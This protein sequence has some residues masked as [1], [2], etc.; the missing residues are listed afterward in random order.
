MY[1]SNTRDK[2]LKKIRQ[3]LLNKSPSPFPEPDF[4]GSV[5]ESNHD[6]PEIEFAEKFSETGGNF[7]FSEDGH[8][9]VINFTNLCVQQQWKNI[10]CRESGITSLFIGFNFPFELSTQP[11]KKANAILT[12]CE[13][14]VAL[15]GSIIITS[16]NNLSLLA[17]FPDVPHIVMAYTHQVRTELK[18]ALKELKIKYRGSLIPSFSIFTGKKTMPLESGNTGKKNAAGEIFL[19][20]VDQ[21]SHDAG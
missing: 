18:D 11:E 12:S 20:L 1:E 17:S 7:I 21:P 5:F 8:D 19:F 15:T 13:M 16:K 14:L 10:I 4:T 2:I 3:A 9:F 6:S